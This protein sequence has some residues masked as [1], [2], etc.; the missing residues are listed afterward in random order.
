MSR[1]ERR[2]KARARAKHRERLERREKG[3]RGVISPRLYRLITLAL[4]GVLVLSLAGWGIAGY[5]SGRAAATKVL[6]VVNGQSI[7]Q[8]E[9][10]TRANVIRFL[11]GLSNIDADTMAGLLE[12]LVDE[13]LIQAE[14][15][16]RGLVVSDEDLAAAEEANTR[17]LEVLYGS[18]LRITAQRLRLGLSRDDLTSYQRIRI[19][20][21]KLYEDVTA[22]VTATEEEILALYEEYKEA[23][24][25]QGLSLEEARDTLAQE[26]T[27]TK[28]GEVYTEFLE[29][30]RAEAVITDPQPGAG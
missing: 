6:K 29:G 21:G 2:A 27:T 18:A 11:Y 10:T 5:V 1:A 26:V 16:R 8:A 24:G 30:L 9:L 17:T 13:V 28:R 25:Q 14:A 23:L 7:T 12:G 20:E 4:V 19:Y 22:G 15:E 3:R